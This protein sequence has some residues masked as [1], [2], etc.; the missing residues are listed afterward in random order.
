MGILTKIFGGTEKRKGTN[1]TALLEAFVMKVDRD[2]F[3]VIGR[4]VVVK[5]TVESGTI[6]SGDKVCLTTKTGN[7]IVCG[8]DIQ[9]GGEGKGSSQTASAGMVIALLLK[10]ADYR[11]IEEGTVI[12]GRP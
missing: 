7:K 9:A 1:G 10:C 11:D 8:A 12:S 5:G 4:G 2:I 3:P 6:S